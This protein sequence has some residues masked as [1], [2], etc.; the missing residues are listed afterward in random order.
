MSGRIIAQVIV[1]VGT[2]VGRAFFAAYKQAAANAA[3]GGGAAA[4][5]RGGGKEGVVD[6]LTRKTGLSMEEACQ[7]LNLQ[8][9]ADLAQLTKNYEHLFNTNDV[10]K[11]GSFYIQSKVVRAKERFDL[12]HAEELKKTQASQQQQSSSPSPDNQSTPPPPPPSS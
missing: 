11:G 8:R 1:S 5:A 3:A 12:E 2:V 10:A 9:D 4:A 7:I 6:A